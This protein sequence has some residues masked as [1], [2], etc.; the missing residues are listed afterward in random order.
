MA[1]KKPFPPTLRE[2]TRYLTFRIH[3]NHEYHKGQVINALWNTA[4]ENL[5]AFDIAKSGFW[6][7]DF[8]EDEQKGIL[9]TNNKKEQRVR[10][11]LTL[12]KEIN[13][14]KAFI[15]IIKESGTLKKAREKL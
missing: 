6:L 8:D 11:T 13:N 10:A 15:Q 4:F 5:G 1:R 12:L 2:K 3:S 7:V 9:R 14:K